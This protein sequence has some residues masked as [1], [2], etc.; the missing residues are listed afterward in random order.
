MQLQRPVNKGTTPPNIH[1]LSW[2]WHLCA[3]QTQRL[4]ALADGMDVCHPHEH[5]F[6]V[7]V[8]FCRETAS[9]R[10]ET[11]NYAKFHF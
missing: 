2:I 7:R 10:E 8:I 5:Y 3:E 6:T 9:E 4:E 1:L 11:K